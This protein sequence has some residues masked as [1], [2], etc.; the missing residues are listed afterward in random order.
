MSLS[1]EEFQRLQEQLLLLRTADYEKQNTIDKLH[2]GNGG[3]C[4][5][6]FSIFWIFSARISAG[7][8]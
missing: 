2:R 5:S 6:L 4:R 3:F 7:F 8:C 1:V